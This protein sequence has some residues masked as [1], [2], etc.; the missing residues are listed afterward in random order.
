MK[1]L[2]RPPALFLQIAFQMYYE[3]Y[4]IMETAKVVRYDSSFVGGYFDRSSH[5]MELHAQ[6]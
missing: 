6:G 3:P 2:K 5:V 4:I 1:R